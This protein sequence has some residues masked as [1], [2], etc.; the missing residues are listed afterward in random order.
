MANVN[1][2]KNINSQIETFFIVKVP[3]VEG[4]DNFD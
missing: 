4:R 2:A 3:A 1:Q